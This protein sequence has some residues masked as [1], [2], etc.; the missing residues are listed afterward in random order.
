[1]TSEFQSST[2]LYHYLSQLSYL[3]R[4]FPLKN[5][6]FYTS[7]ILL[8][9]LWGYVLW[10]V[11]FCI[12]R[13]YVYDDKVELFFFIMWCCST[14]WRYM[15]K[16]LLFMDWEQTFLR[17]EIRAFVVCCCYYLFSLWKRKF[18]SRQ[19]RTQFCPDEIIYLNTTLV[20]EIQK[21]TFLGNLI[22]L[23][24]LILHITSHNEL[25]HRIVQNLWGPKSITNGTRTCLSTYANTFV[26]LWKE[27]YICSIITKSLYV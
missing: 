7:V 25:S 3:F 21:M 12:V 14:N 18:K 26:Y 17:L 11:V 1:M 5:V 27:C 4:H 19:G 2:F 8:W 6:A 15:K 24:T 13:F 22:T 9:N 10:R 16:G 23:T 20:D